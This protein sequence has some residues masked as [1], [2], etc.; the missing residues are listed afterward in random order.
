MVP[1]ELTF[2]GRPQLVGALPRQR[3]RAHAAAQRPRR[4]RRRRAA[5]RLDAARS[6]RRRRARRPALRPRGVRHEG[7]RREHGRGRVHAGRARRPA[8]RRPDRQHGHRGGVDRRRR[9]VRRARCCRPT[10]RSSP[11]RAASSSGSRAAAACCRASRC[12]AAP[13]MRASHQLAARAGRRGQRDREDGDRA[14]RRAPPARALGGR[15]RG[16]P[17]SRPATACRRSSAAASGSSP[18]PA[19]CT[20]ECH[21]EYLPDRADERGLRLARRARVLRLDRRGRGRRPLAARAP[22]RDRVGRRR[23]AA[24]RGRRAT[25]RSCRRCWPPAA[26]SARSRALGGLDNWHDGATLTVEAGIPAVCFGPGDVHRAHTVDE[27]VPIDD[28]VACAQRIALA[29][30][31]FCA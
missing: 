6:V 18:I 24:G 15:A 1:D 27:Y 11:S 8:G 21:I 26:T 28:L 13:A 29:A 4:R 14:R 9:A 2:E 16:I 31:R 17:T 12:A 5:R 20:L 3:R 22:A 19:S 10:P 23:R 30:M 7:R 25:I